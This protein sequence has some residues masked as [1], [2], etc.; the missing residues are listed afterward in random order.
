MK[1]QIEITA[2]FKKDYKKALKRG[3]KE[4]LLQKVIAI[5]ANGEKLPSK[6][7]DHSLN[8]QYL[9]Y[10]ECHLAPDWLLIYRIESNLLVL[11]LTR[12]GTHSDLF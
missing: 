9:G 11:V 1:Y 10:R 4:E 3:Y 7:K 5:L 2:K 8:G 6:Y 12:T